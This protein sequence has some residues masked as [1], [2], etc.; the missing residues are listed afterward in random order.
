MTISTPPLLLQK[1]FW[2]SW[3]ASKRAAFRARAKWLQTARPSQITPPGNWRIW[4]LLAGRGWGKTRVGAEDCAYHAL[5]HDNARV[6][7]VAP[8]HAD[9]RDTC[10]EGESGLLRVI[11]DACIQTWNRSMG[12]LLLVN[13]SRFK[14][15]SADEPERLR[16][17]QFTRV[18]ADE[19]AAWKNVQAFDQI[20]MGLR[21]GDDPRLVITT[22][23]KPT[24]LVKQ[25]LGRPEVMVTRGKSEENAANLA[26][27]VLAEMRARYGQ[28]RWARQEMD[29]EIIETVDGALWR[30]EQIE[31]LRVGKMPDLIEQIVIAI[32]PAVTSNGKSDETGIVAAARGVDKNF[33]VLADVSGRYTPDAWGARVLA[34]RDE[35]KA[36]LIIG[37]VN[38]GGDL[39]A[40]VLRMLDE[41]VLFKPVRATRAKAVRAWPVA[42]LYERGLVRHVGQ[43]PKLEDQMCRFTENGL[44]SGSPDRVD[45]LVWALTELQ[46]GNSGTP[47]VRALV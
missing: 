21:L 24:A 41:N 23:P 44:A 13:G 10:V 1:H 34:L 46:Q 22:T 15:F 40:R 17:P 29:A 35:L 9:A 30:A 32:D 5:W 8:T 7:V 25:L 47:R 27:G 11:P 18:W 38:E 33:Y 26:P 14:L 45:A 39:I 2:M 19:L 43:H 36:D 16:G 28:T 42:M 31:D 12:E 4:F 37:E 6:G 3:P 20:M